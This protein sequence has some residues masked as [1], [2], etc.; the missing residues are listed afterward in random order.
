MTVVSEAEVRRRSGVMS[1]RAWRLQTP[2]GHER[3][4]KRR[5]SNEPVFGQ[6]KEARGFRRFS[7]RGLSK[8]RGEWDLVAL[9]H[10]IVKLH[11]AVSAV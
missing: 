5:T 11:R 6:I 7:L 9:A 2:E 1:R 10:N 8:V 4:I 3:R